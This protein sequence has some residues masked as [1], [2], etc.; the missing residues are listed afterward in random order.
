MTFR[1]QQKHHLVFLANRLLD[2]RARLPRP[3]DD[4]RDRADHRRALRRRRDR[5]HERPPLFRCSSLLWYALPLQR[6]LS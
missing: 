2:R 3:G 6:R 4:R 5:G 1:L